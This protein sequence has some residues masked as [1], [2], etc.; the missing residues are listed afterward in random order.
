MLWGMAEPVGIRRRFRSNG[1][2]FGRSLSGDDG[3]FTAADSGSYRV[4]P[5]G[6]V[7]MVVLEELY[8]KGAALEKMR[9]RRPEVRVGGVVQEGAY[10]PGRVGLCRKGGRKSLGVVLP[11]GLALEGLC[12]PGR[13]RLPVLWG[14]EEPV[15]ASGRRRCSSVFAGFSIVPAPQCGKKS[16]KRT[17]STDFS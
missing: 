12:R 14:G 1:F 10:R 4:C 17:D 9:R 8:R 7:G 2:G 11:D 16:G 5:E 3:G 15:R 6:R 13:W